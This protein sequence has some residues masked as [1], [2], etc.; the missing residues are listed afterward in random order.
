[1]DVGV[2][3]GLDIYGLEGDP[4]PMRQKI[5]KDI[6]FIDVLIDIIYYPFRNG[7]DLLE[8]LDDSNPIKEV[9]SLTYT[10]L[11]YGIKE[12][13]PN[14]LYG[15][16]WLNFI[17]DQALQTKEQ[18][19]IKAGQ[20]LTELIDNNQRILEHR[21]KKD[22]IYRF[23]DFLVEKD[24]DEKFL[25]ILRAIC[26]CDDRPM[27]ENQKEISTKMLVVKET[28]EAL[29]FNI[30][31]M[32]GSYILT[33]NI[34]DY[35]GIKLW[36][37]YENSH[38]KKNDNGKTYKFF[39]T[40]IKLLSDLCKDRNYIAIDILQ[41]KLDY[42]IIFGIMKYKHSYP[43]PGVLGI[44]EAFTILLE[45]L[46]IDVSPFQEI[47]LPYCIK[48]WDE[49]D[50]D[51]MFMEMTHNLK[52]YEPLK[53]YLLEYISF[54]KP[55]TGDD[56]GDS[57][58][59]NQHCLDLAVFNLVY[60]MLK[61]S[62]FTSVEDLNKIINNLKM[63]L[64]NSV[65]NKYE[66]SGGDYG[67]KIS[68][69]ASMGMKDSSIPDFDDDHFEEIEDKP[70]VIECKKRVCE[71]LHFAIDIQNELRVK[72]FFKKLKEWV[73]GAGN[74]FEDYQQGQIPSG[75]SAGNNK[76]VKS[77]Q[78]WN[79]YLIKETGRKLDEVMNAN[80]KLDIE[81]DKLFS[82]LYELVLYKDNNLKTKALELIKKLYSQNEN[83]GAT[84]FDI[85]IIDDESSKGKYRRAKESSFILNTIGDIMEKWYEMS[86]AVELGHLVSFIYY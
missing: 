34:P 7:E 2:D 73:G 24:K 84:L 16:Q 22:T 70:M 85:Q 19:D 55:E 68:P 37:L 38:K 56:D 57:D 66:G 76:S 45:N 78:E 10:C 26:I 46:W 9:M 32:N 5:L 27:L 82:T 71:I 1:M 12:F 65:R 4:I 74:P 28:Q 79:E 86:D 80:S 69:Y 77:K 51:S 17:T 43:K 11:R 58:D 64:S 33:M 54:I 25:L 47:E 81:K 60:K 18:N 31:L 50:E 61:L 53:Q 41:E 63:Y 8:E 72:E 75:F 13:R 67:K 21:I 3:S 15:S 49:L 42:D 59:G 20:T 6:G 36:D 48:I 83:L 23:I 14:E 40:M 62:F 44:R 29:L 35:K 30:E 39:I 52:K